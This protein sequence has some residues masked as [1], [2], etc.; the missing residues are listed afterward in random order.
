MMFRHSRLS[1]LMVATNKVE[2]GKEK[3]PNNINKVPVQAANFDWSEIVF[4]NFVASDF[5][6][7]P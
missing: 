3:N 1:I 6:D 4:V 5:C 2:Q 7:E